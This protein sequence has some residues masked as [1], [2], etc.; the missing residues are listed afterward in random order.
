M[1]KLTNDY[2]EQEV[3]SANPAKLVDLLFQ[4]AIRDLYTAQEAWPLMPR[5]LDAMKSAL[6]AQAII[7]ELNGCLNHAEGGKL[8]RNL[9]RL[10]EYMQYR[11]SEALTRRAPEDCA[12]VAEVH[13]L[14][15]SLGEAW[16]EMAASNGQVSEV[17]FNSILVA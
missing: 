6:H 10:Y 12:I 3:A 13:S 9:S 4:R 17:A 14:L 5:N 15:S 8:A 7:V 11:L 1:K 16:S 2:I